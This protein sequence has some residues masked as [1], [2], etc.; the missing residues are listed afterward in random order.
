MILTTPTGIQPNSSLF[1]QNSPL[2]PY[3]LTIKSYRRGI[4][5]SESDLTLQR[6]F[7]TGSLRYAPSAGGVREPVEF[8]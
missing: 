5:A 7:G 3:C 4:V 1:C 6:Q 2:A 8:G